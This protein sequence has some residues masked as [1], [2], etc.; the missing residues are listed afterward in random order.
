MSIKKFDIKGLDRTANVRVLLNSDLG[1]VTLG[2]VYVNNIFD[3]NGDPFVSGGGASIT[4]SSTPPQGEAGK[5]WIN[6]DTGEFYA[7]VANVW[8][9][10]VNGVGET[11]ATGATGPSGTPGAQG[12]PGLSGQ[13]G[14]Q[15]STGAT[16]AIG[17]TG[18]IG[19]DGATGP[20]GATGAEF[21]LSVGETPPINPQN[22]S[23]WWASNTG[24]LFFYYSDGDSSQWVS[25]AVGGG[26]GGISLGSREAKS[27][28][29]TSIANN[30]TENVNITGYKGYCLYK[31]Q[32]SAAAWVRIYTD[33]ASRT[34]DA[35]RSES[36]DPGTN[37]G[38][39]AEVITT[40]ANTIVVAPGTIGFNNE[41]TPTT[42][43]PLAVTNKSGSSA[44]ITVTLTVLQIEV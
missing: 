14:S 1:N 15:G 34:A 37:A 20:V 6:G 17:A 18:P 36:V 43:I 19:Q 39:I 44:A 33:D 25:A 41:A 16:G 3:A 32:T 22:G 21:V 35:A 29:T 27:V 31:I 23:L 11:G 2:N 40:G 42:T 10:P 13:P 12:L 9:Q 5:L 30:A 24:S 38:V 8:I 7:Y 26:G 28:T 4:V